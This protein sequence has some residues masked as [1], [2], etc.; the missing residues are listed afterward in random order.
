MRERSLALS[1]L[2]SMITSSKDLCVVMADRS[3]G[4][5]PGVSSLAYPFY[6]VTLTPCA[7]VSDMERVGR[8]VLVCVPVSLCVSVGLGRG[9]C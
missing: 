7:C 3:Y 6:I 8:C 1:N 2:S 9:V 4:K 5:K